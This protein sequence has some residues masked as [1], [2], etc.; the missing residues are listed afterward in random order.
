MN[1]LIE[2][3]SNS[4]QELSGPHSEHNARPS[5]TRQSS[6]ELDPAPVI[7]IRD[8]ASTSGKERARISNEEAHRRVDELYMVPHI[9]SLLAL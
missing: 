9:D 1:T 5:V 2:R 4:D 7:L 3:S 6:T 8:A